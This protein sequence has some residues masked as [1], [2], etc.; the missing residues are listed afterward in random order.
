MQ[1][2]PLTRQVIKSSSYSYNYLSFLI[3]FLNYFYVVDI[4]MKSP[5]G[6]LSAI[7]W[8]L[9]PFYGVM[10]IIYVFYAVGWLVVSALNW[11][12]LLRIQVISR[13]YNNFHYLTELCP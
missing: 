7:E 6:Y 13:F 2:I 9:L 8:P 10:C 5:S 11:R 12:D 1:S 4:E 3:V